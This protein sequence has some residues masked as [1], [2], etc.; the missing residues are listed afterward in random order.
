MTY[1]QPPYGGPWGAEP[2]DGDRLGYGRGQPQGNPQYA[3]QSYPPPMYP[4]PGGVWPQSNPGARDPRD[5]A[6]PLYGATF[7]QAVNR[8]F[9]SYAKFSGRASQSEYWWSV[10]A[11]VLVLVALF[12]LAIISANVADGDTAAGVF[13]IVI[14]LVALGFAL[15]T[16]A[17][18]VRRLHDANMSGWL[19]LLN[20]IPLVN[21][22]V[23]IVIGLL[24]TNPLGARYDNPSIS[25]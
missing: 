8:F 19:Y 5:L 15:P 25:G 6:L 10:L 16:I 20:F 2:G 12:A 14:L 11:Y 3:G 22:V 4:A 17:V 21:Y 7:G 24:S 1:G 23:W 13:G 9:R 18:S